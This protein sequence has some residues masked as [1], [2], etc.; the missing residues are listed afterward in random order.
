MPKSQT[1][2]AVTKD[3]TAT[4]LVFTRS[5]F[6]QDFVFGAG[7]SAYQYEGAVDEDGRSPSIWDAFTHAGKIADKS[8]GD[9]AADGYHKYME[10]VKLMY[11]TGL[12]AYRILEPLVFG[13]YPEVMRKNV[14]SRLPPFTKDQSELI[15]GSLDFIGINHYYSLYVN[16]RPLVTGVRDYTADMSIYCRGSPTDP[17]VGKGAPKNVP[18]DPKG[19][20][21]VLEY[22]KEAYGNLPIYVQENGIGSADDNLYDTDRIGYLSSHMESML[23][24]VRNGADVR[25]YFAWSFMDVFEFLGGYQSKFGLYHVDLAEERRPRRARLSARWYFAFLK[26]KAETS[27]VLSRMQHQNPELD[28]IS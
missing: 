15:R 9:V 6:P 10:D 3:A 23:N 16:D 21:L 2:D 27:T 19:L 20:Q 5:D 22:L 11:E 24:A 1:G 13:D 14:G 18:S 4:D 12:E 25:G 7:T 26:K 8:T 28:A 17:P